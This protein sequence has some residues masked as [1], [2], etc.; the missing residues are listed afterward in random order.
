MMSVLTECVAVTSVAATLGLLCWAAWTDFAVRLI[1]NAAC[2]GVAVFGLVHRAT[3]GLEAVLLSSGVALGVFV[4]L[5]VMH[6]RGLM[7]GGDVKLIAAVVLGFVALVHL[8]SRHLLGR[9]P[10][11]LLSSD[12]SG[13][14]AHIWHRVAAIE[15]WRVRRHGSLPY[16]VAIASGGAWVLLT[17]SGG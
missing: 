4:L 10:W 5:V 3:A 16:G 14:G 9:R 15:V 12:L 8:V 17:G 11:L 7:G 1:P 2:A 6:A 13:R